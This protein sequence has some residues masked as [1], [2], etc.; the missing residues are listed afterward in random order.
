VNAGMPFRDAYKKVGADIESGNFNYDANIKH[1]HQGSISNLCTAEI[2]Q[3][4]Q[5]I[6]DSFPFQKVNAAISKLIAG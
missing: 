5:N 4:M 2:K 3:Q 6:F 1:T